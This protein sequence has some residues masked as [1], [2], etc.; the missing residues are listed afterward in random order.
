MAADCIFIL[1]LVV[2]ESFARE[3]VEM[4]GDRS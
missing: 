2:M 1:M 3:I 4:V